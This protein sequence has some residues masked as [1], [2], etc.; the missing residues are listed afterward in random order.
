MMAT[1]RRRLYTITFAL[2]FQPAMSAGDLGV[3][4]DDSF[5]SETRTDLRAVATDVARAVSDIFGGSSPPLN[6]PIV[7]SLSAPPPITCVDNWPDPMQI[8]IHITIGDRGY[9]QFAF[10]LGHELGH[11]MLGVHRSNGLIE[12]LAT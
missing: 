6:R 3:R 7:C 2:M 11:V 4:L 12:V 8:H 5:P 9:A 10:Q 1:G